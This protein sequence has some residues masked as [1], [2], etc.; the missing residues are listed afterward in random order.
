MVDG[1]RNALLGY[2]Y[3]FVGLLGLKARALDPRESNDSLECELVVWAGKGTVIHEEFGQD[4]AFRL[5]AGGTVLVQFK[6]SASA[7]RQEIDLPDLLEIIHRFDESSR[8]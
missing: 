8:N 4:A 3:Q 2:L 5:L 6:Y 7:D 1:A